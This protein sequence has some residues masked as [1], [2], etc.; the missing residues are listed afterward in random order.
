M[1]EGQGVCPANNLPANILVVEDDTLVRMDA[2]DMI[3]SAGY[4]VIEAENA[5]E[6]IAILE[7]AGDVH[8]VFSDVDMPGSLDGRELLEL[9]HR[10]WPDIRLLLTSG[11]HRVDAA[12]MPDHGLFVPKPYSQSAIVDRIR[13]MLAA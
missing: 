1:R 4:H 7:N 11:H 8:L 2:A 12:A 5:D 6:A 13:A 10:R 9:V 3:A